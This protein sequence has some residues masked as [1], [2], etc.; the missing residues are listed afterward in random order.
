MRFRARFRCAISC[1]LMHSAP[2]SRYYYPPALHITCV[3]IST[4]TD[5]LKAQQHLQMV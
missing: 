4:H 3:G 5:S 2:H 1:D